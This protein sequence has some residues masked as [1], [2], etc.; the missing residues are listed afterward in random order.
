MKPVL[1]FPRSIHCR[2]SSSAYYLQ[3]HYS[4]LI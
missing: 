1:Y 4:G 3:L 2:Y